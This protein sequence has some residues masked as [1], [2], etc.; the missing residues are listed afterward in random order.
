MNVRVR[1]VSY[2]DGG[3]EVR[4][5]DDGELLVNGNLTGVFDAAQVQ[6]LVAAITMLFAAQESPDD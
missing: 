6:D 1:S 3:L 4:L 5:D 2:T